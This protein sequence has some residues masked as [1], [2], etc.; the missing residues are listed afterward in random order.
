[1]TQKFLIL[2]VT[3]FQQLNYAVTGLPTTGSLFQLSNVFSLYGYQPVS[4]IQLT[5]S[6]A[7]PIDVT[8]SNHR[9][10]YNRPIPD[11]ATTNMVR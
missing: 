4:G 10:Y 9:I 2:T 11:L 3:C 7:L 8:G 6:T 1:M 5:A